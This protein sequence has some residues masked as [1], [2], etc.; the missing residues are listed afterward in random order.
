[1]VSAELATAIGALAMVLI[2]VLSAVAAGIDLLRV[3]DAA[4]VG[5]RAAARGDSEDQVR[6]AI[7]RIAP[8]GASVTVA[9]RGPDVEVSVRADW[10][11]VLRVLVPGELSGTA[12][13]R[14]EQQPDG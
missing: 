10:P 3:T 9:A 5:A 4:R 6:S 7:A 11:P 8:D 13:G 12:T 1:M 2:L 14:K